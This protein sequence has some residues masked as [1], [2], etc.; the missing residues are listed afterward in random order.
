MSHHVVILEMKK[1]LHGVDG[2]L[3]KAVAFAGTKKFDPNTLLQAR[4]APDMYPLIRQI[5]SSCD[6][7]KF[8]AARVAAKD[9]PSHP[10]TETTIDEL[11]KRIASVVSYLETFKASDFDGAD[12]RVV[13]LPRWEGRSMTATNY[14]VEH[15]LPNFFFHLS[16]T[17]AILRHNGVELG[18]RD[19]LGAFTWR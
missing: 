11:K 10:D 5:Q 18:K 7:A 1:L 13:S 12:D 19:Y 15:S 17:Y 16:M 2:W 9:P 6:S 3:D 8:A 14:L 4:L